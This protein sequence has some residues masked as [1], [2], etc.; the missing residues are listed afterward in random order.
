MTEDKK[1]VLIVEDEEVLVNAA[2]K[3]LEL[4]GFNVVSARSVEQALGYLEDL[5]KVDLVWLD[6]YLLGSKNGLDLVTKMKAEDSKWKGIPIFVVSNTATH[7]KVQGY[8]HLGVGKYFVKS[9]YK[10]DEIIKDVTAILVK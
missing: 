1:T 5:E 4:N 10:L 3:K 2:K 6:H 9:N 7:D 8:L